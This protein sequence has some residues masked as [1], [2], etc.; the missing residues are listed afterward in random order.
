M[1][2]SSMSMAH[3]ACRRGHIVYA[4]LLTVNNTIVRNNIARWKGTEPDQASK[5][6][7]FVCWR[8]ILL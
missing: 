6:T 1:E 3:H 7:V 4:T 5:Q 8:N 2:P